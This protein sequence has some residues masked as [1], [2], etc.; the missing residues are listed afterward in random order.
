MLALRSRDPDVPDVQHTPDDPAD[1]DASDSEDLSQ[2]NHD[3][4]D[5]PGITLHLVQEVLTKVEAHVQCASVIWLQ[6]RHSFRITRKDK[7]VNQVRVPNL[8]KKLAQAL[9]T[10]NHQNLQQAFHMALAQ[11]E[12]FLNSGM[13]STDQP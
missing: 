6:S 1:P 11:G 12:E 9:K 10:E 13:D 8:K 7:V 5:G 3:T 4:P 2:M